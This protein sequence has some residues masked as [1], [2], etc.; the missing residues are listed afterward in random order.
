MYYSGLASVDRLGMH[1]DSGYVSQ[2]VEGTGGVPTDNDIRD[3]ITD[4]TS[5]WSRVGHVYWD[6]GIMPIAR[7]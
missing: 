7:I 5:F 6:S 4:S 2:R 3:N 1:Q